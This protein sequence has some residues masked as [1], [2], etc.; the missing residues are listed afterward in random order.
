MAACEC[1]LEKDEKPSGVEGV[2]WFQPTLGDE[3]DDRNIR[4]VCRFGE[5][6][7]ERRAVRLPG[8]R[9]WEELGSTVNFY[10]DITPPL[11]WERVGRCWKEFPHP[12]LPCDPDPP[13][14]PRRPAPEPT[15]GGNRP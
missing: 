6:P 11:S 10:R 15:R 8:G 14:P 4:A 5:E 2:N 1:F 9:G 3:P 12:V 13:R 7:F